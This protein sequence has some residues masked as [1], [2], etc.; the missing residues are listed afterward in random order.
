MGTPTLPVAV[1]GDRRLEILAMDQL[2]AFLGLPPSDAGAS[3]QELVAATDRVLE[4]IERA[5]AQ[6]PTERLSDPTPNRGRDL[7]ELVFNIY[8]RILPMAGALD[9]GYYDWTHKDDY[10]PSRAFRTT[11]NLT[12]FCSEIRT[13]WLERARLVGDDLAEEGVET[14]RGMVTHLQ[15]LESQAIHTAQHLRQ[16]YVFMKQIGIAPEQELTAEGMAP[17]VL[18]DFVF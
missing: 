5:V 2:R 8:D 10:A 18:S 6:V 9:T 15:L 1:Q 7:R 16:I 17:I 3:Y 4:A 11:G 12:K 13:A 14:D